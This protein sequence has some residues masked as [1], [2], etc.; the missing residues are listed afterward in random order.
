VYLWKVPVLDAN[1]VQCNACLQKL[2]FRG[3]QM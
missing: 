1:F 2:K 3:L